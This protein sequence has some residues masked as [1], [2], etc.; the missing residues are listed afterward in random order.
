MNLNERKNQL[1]NEIYIAKKMIKQNATNFK[2]MS[3]LIP[4]ASSLNFVV[5]RLLDNPIENKMSELPRTGASIFNFDKVS[6]IGQIIKI[7]Y[8][9]I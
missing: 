9:S 1:E 6:W 3:Y 8:K 7:V 4:Q 5:S 2:P